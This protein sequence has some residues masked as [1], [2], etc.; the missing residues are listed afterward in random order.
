[1]SYGFRGAQFLFF[2]DMP[3]LEPVQS[4]QCLLQNHTRKVSF[5]SYQKNL[6]GVEKLGLRP[7]AT[8]GSRAQA[9]TKAEA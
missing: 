6:N 4:E 8:E 5:I 9:L 3:S 7:L 2:V 1:M